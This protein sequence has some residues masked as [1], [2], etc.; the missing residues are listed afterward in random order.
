MGR[1]LA[2]VM[3]FSVAACGSDRDEAEPATDP[4]SEADR[5][6]QI[7]GPT[8]AAA[9]TPADSDSLR[10]EAGPCGPAPHS[11]TS[12]APAGGGDLGGTGGGGGAGAPGLVVPGPTPG[13]G[14]PAKPRA[15][16]QP[17]GTVT[18]SVTE[19]DGSIH[20]DIVDRYM[21]RYS[22]R[23]RFCYQRA[24]GN[25]RGFDANVGAKLIVGGDGKVVKVELDGTNRGTLF[26]CLEAAL[27]SRAFPKPDDGGI[28]TVNAV[29]KMKLNDGGGAS[30]VPPVGKGPPAPRVPV[31]SYDYEQ[32][33][34]VFASNVDSLRACVEPAYA[35]DPAARGTLSVAFT[36]GD[37]GAAASVDV[38]SELDDT[39]KSC[40]ADATSRLAFPTHPLKLA[41][42]VRCN[43]EYGTLSADE[44]RKTATIIDA[45][46]GGAPG[47]V[48]QSDRLVVIRATP[49]APYEAVYQT[50]ADARASGAV[51]FAF[52]APSG[53]DWQA[54]YTPP[55]PQARYHGDPIERDPLHIHI[56][57]DAIRVR[58]AKKIRAKD[59]AH[60]FDGVATAIAT[61]T[62]KP[63]YAHRTDVAIQAD[64]DV[65]YSALIR[66][67]QAAVRHGL[68][69]VSLQAPNR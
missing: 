49:E 28:T 20:R 1:W 60:D 45:T 54:A 23:L 56:A 51:Y 29:V 64:K 58:G 67:I 34:D 2:V 7:V 44:A 13:G 33:F 63:T 55:M 9:A 46:A 31:G 41:Q 30:P 62:G 68:T 3:V 17:R 53:D 26:S 69:H 35:A 12:S 8:D 6:S 14:A 10:F 36:V 18:V 39:A 52:D 42:H 59:G 48:F 40:L 57:D 24:L 16:K 37:T 61:L 32:V 47:A 65:P 22:S 15:P 5:T 4:G 21:R 27:T 43:F 25:G 11:G 19:V 66:V 38:D 50:V